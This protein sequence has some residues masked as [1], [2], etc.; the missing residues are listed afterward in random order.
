MDQQRIKQKNLKKYLKTNENKHNFP[1]SMGC[2]KSSSKSEVHS[3]T[4]LSQFKSI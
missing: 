3:D 2:G 1:K 4:G